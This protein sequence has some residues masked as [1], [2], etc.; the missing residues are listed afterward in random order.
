MIIPLY[1]PQ[2][3]RLGRIDTNCMAEWCSPVETLTPTYSSFSRQVQVADPHS[4]SLCYD[5]S[6]TRGG[7][8]LFVFAGLG[9]IATLGSR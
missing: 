5:G 9:Q 6:S 1:F 3:P 4:L 7:L 8:N 2:N